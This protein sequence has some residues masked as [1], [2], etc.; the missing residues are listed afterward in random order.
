MLRLD[1][2]HV[3][4]GSAPMAV[5][6]LRGINLTVNT[7]EFVTIIGGNGAGKSTLLKVLAGEITPTSGSIYIGQTD[8]TGWSP[9]KRADMIAQVFQDPVIGTCQEFSVEENMALASTRGVGRKLRSALSQ[10][11]REQFFQTL[12]SLNMG[13]E[14]HLQTRVG[15]LSGGQRQALSLVMAILQPAKILILDEPT[16]ALD[17]KTAGSV[18]SIVR[19]IIAER[20]LTALMVTHS[21]PQALE[22][23][24]RTIALH[25]GQVAMDVAGKEKNSLEPAD[26]LKFFL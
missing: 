1:N 17:P 23:G 9:A 19:K 8:I 22:E 12:S 26:M 25:Q 21:M 16:A 13:L 14:N 3:H 5:H 18:I 11:N 15:A 10:S 2:I 24:T 7:G 20:K 4:F 6:A